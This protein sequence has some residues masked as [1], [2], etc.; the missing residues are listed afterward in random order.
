MWEY[1]RIRMVKNPILTYFKQ[2]FYAAY[3][4]YVVKLFAPR[5]SLSNLTRGR[6]GPR[7]RSSRLEVF[8][9]KSV[10]KISSRFMG[11]NTC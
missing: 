8:L 4:K 6:S 5:H 9:G 11:E 2:L 7:C 10:L 3:A 1:G